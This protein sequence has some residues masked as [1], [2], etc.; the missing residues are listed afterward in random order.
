MP[1]TASILSVV[2]RL[3]FL[4]LAT[5]VRTLAIAIAIA[6]VVVVVLATAPIVTTVPVARPV[7]SAPS[8]HQPAHALRLH[9][10]FCSCLSFT[11]LLFKTFLPKFLCSLCLGA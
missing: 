11:P 2:P 10:F 8:T 7:H 3:P 5:S 9:G 1:A 6:I 4:T